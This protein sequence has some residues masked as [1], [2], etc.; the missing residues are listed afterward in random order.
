MKEGNVGSGCCNC[1]RN[2]PTV[3]LNPCRNFGDEAIARF[4]G[5]S[6]RGFLIVAICWLRS[7]PEHELDTPGAPKNPRRN[8]RKTNKSCRLF[9]LIQTAK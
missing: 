7:R 3:P 5:L 2:F 1:C 6:K 4:P 9:T 8:P